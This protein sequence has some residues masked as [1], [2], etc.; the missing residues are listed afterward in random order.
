M[1]KLSVLHARV[2]VILVGPVVVIVVVAP[3]HC[4]GICAGIVLS[5]PAKKGIGFRVS[6]FG[7]KSE[8]RRSIMMKVW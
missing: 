7:L 6:G 3:Y 8:G 2:L 1:S 4:L 5:S